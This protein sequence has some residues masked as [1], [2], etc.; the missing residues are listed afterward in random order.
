LFDEA[1]FWVLECYVGS[2]RFCTWRKTR[3]FERFEEKAILNVVTRMDRIDNAYLASLHDNISI[4]VSFV[5]NG[6][7]KIIAAGLSKFAM[8]SSSSNRFRRKIKEEFR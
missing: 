1:I 2:G 4:D 3:R 7:K 8:A 6:A 5:P